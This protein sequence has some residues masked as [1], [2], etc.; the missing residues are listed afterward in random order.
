MNRKELKIMENKIKTV[1][2]YLFKLGISP[3]LTGYHYILEA[4]ELIIK[5]PNIIRKGM[6]TKVLYPTIGK[7]NNVTSGSVERCIRHAITKGLDRAPQ[8]VIQ[9]LFG[10][11]IKFESGTITN[12]QFLA[13]IM[14]RLEFENE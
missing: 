3:D 2:G 7:A 4:I 6:V 1:R 10:N 5:E 8:K 14:T 11:V 12:S 9:E 13:I